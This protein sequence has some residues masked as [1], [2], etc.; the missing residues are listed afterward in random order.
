MWLR[1]LHQGRVVKGKKKKNKNQ[2]KSRKNP[3]DR[4]ILWT[5]PKRKP[6]DISQEDFDS[7]PDDLVVREVNAYICIPG[8]RT[9]EITVVTTLL[10]AIE[11]PA[12]DILKLYDK[13]WEAEINLRH[14][15]TTLGMD[16]LTGKTPEMVRKEIYTYLLAYNLQ[17][18]DNVSG[19]NYF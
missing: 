7:T 9:E 2:K 15:K 1:L 3:H 16:I 19:G 13:R 5:K 10:D 14:I 8:F 6:K 12:H 11:Y 18:N 4:L 17:M